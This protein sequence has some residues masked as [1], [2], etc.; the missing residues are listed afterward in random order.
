MLS[1]QLDL[2]SD[3]S[4]TLG[5]YAPGYPRGCLWLWVTV[6]LSAIGANNRV[7]TNN[8]KTAHGL[9]L[10]DPFCG[11]SYDPLTFEF[12]SIILGLIHKRRL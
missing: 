4:S 3:G 6:F 5:L 8:M 10:F 7:G 9:T 2:M 12:I 1:R 11:T